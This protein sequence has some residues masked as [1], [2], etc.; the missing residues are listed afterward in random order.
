MNLKYLKSFSY[1]FSIFF[2]AVITFLTIFTF[3]ISEKPLKINF[4]NL[5][6]R[7]SSIL[8]KHNIEEIGDIFVSF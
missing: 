7:Q 6:D 1:F 3:V 5:F 2:L 8:K 4:L